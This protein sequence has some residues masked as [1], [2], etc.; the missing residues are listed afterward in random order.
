MIKMYIKIEHKQVSNFNKKLQYLPYT[1]FFYM[2]FDRARRSEVTEEERKLAAAEYKPS[3]ENS[4]SDSDE[5]ASLAT[6]KEKD[7][8]N[9]SVNKYNMWFSVCFCCRH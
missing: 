8:L 4:D 3:A 9:R 1:C 2:F 6:L 5:D 7:N